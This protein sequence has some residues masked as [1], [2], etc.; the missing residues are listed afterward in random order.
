MRVRF[1]L[2]CPT[3]EDCTVVVAEG[4][5]DGHIHVSLFIESCECP[6]R[7]KLPE[8]KQEAARY[9]DEEAEASD[10][11]ALYNKYPEAV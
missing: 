8:A 7:P 6:A 3:C 11:G 1:E 5:E 2:I 9:L 10:W 4:T